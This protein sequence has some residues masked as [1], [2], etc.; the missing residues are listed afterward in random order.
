MSSD[1]ME[2]LAFRVAEKVHDHERPCCGLSDEE[3]GSV[4]ELLKTK[5]NAIKVFIYI[6]GAIALYV[7]KDLYLFVAGNLTIK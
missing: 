5:R 2:E 4:K 6:F 1:Q 7:L 3:C